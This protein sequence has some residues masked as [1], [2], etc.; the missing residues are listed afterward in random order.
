MVHEH[1][2][3]KIEPFVVFGKCL[4][5]EKWLEMFHI[6]MFGLCTAH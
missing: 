6:G 5:V 4:L 2:S 3:Y 1:N